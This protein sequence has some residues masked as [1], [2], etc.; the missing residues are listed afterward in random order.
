LGMMSTLYAI[1][2]TSGPVASLFAARAICPI[3]SRKIMP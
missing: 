3:S 2:E 1:T